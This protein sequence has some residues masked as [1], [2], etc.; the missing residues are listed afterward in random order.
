MSYQNLIYVTLGTTAFYIFYR[1][2]ES[3]RARER[4]I[5]RTK[6]IY[7]SNIDINLVTDNE[8]IGELSNHTFLR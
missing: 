8:K 1:N 7:L 2:L 5:R 6:K 3:T 4:K